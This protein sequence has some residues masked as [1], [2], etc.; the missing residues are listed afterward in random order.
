MQLSRLKYRAKNR[1]PSKMIIQI[2]VLMKKLREGDIGTSRDHCYRKHL[3]EVSS[4]LRGGLGERRS[5]ENLRRK[6]ECREAVWHLCSVV[7]IILL[8]NSEFS[9]NLCQ[10]S[11]QLKQ[12]TI[13]FLRMRRKVKMLNKFAQIIWKTALILLFMKVKIWIRNH[14]LKISENI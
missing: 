2:I 5:C 14:C 4:Y 12:S 11:Y 9:R 1:L 6:L 8:P 10:S 3:L 7:A 13:N